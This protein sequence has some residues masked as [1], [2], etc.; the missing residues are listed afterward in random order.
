MIP[1]PMNTQVWLAAGVTDMRKGFASLAAQAEQ[2][3]KQNPFNGHMFVFRGRRGD[4]IK[5]IWWVSHGRATGSRDH[6]ASRGRACS[7][8]DWRRADLS[9]H[10]PRTARSP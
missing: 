5:I 1:V 9:G 8:S 7:R 6:G 10:P 4:L 3:T 2:T